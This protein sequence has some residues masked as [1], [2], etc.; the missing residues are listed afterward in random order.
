MEFCY[1]AQQSQIDKDTLAQMDAAIASFHH[2]HKIFRDAGVYDDFSLPCQHSLCH[3]WY[4]IQ[5][6]GTPNGLCLS[7]TQSKHIKTIKE[8]WCCSSCNEPL[9]QMLLTNQ[10]LDKLV[11]AHVDFAS[12]RMLDGLLMAANMPAPPLHDEDNDIMIGD[13][14]GMTSLGD[15]KLTQYPC[16]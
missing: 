16:K 13:A 2:E 4:M 10:Q 3:Y 8:P 15:V 1:F 12:H 6:F 9:G 7:I 14:P 5:K 11:A